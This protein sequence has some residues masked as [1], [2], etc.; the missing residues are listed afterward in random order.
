MLG[1]PG[2]RLS[3]SPTPAGH[4]PPPGLALPLHPGSTTTH[5]HLIPRASAA[6]GAG[7]DPWSLLSHHPAR[8]SP[9]L[10]QPLTP[11]VCVSGAHGALSPQSRRPTPSRGVLVTDPASVPDPP[12]HLCNQGQFLTWQGPCSVWDLDVGSAQIWVQLVSR[13]LGQ[14]LELT[15]LCSW[16][17]RLE[18]GVYLTSSGGLQGRDPQALRGAAWV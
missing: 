6:L 2:H 15:R 8:Q 9:G 12:L 7:G 3:H 10:L 13:A 17:Q 14:W 5:V 16:L 18:P 1:T 4:T 11:T